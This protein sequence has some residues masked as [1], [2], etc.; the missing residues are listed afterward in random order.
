MYIVHLHAKEWFA[1]AHRACWW[2][3]MQQYMSLIGRDR[4]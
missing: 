2:S 3:F 1:L 4:S